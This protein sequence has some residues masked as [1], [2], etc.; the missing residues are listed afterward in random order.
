[1]EDVRG[2]E[3]GSYIWGR[4]VHNIR[5]E[6]LW[7]DVTM[8][9]GSKWK[10]LFYELETVHGLDVGNDAH[11]WLLH[12]IFLPNLNRDAEVWAATWNQHIVARRGERHMAPAQMYLHGLAEHGQCGLLPGPLADDAPE[13]PANGSADDAYAGYG[14]DWADLE[15][16]R[17]REH[18]DMHN[19]ND[20]DPS[21]PFLSNQPN[22]LSHV[23]VPDTRCPFTHEQLQLLD[24]QLSLLPCSQQNTVQGY[25]E[26]WLAA[27]H[28][29]RVICDMPL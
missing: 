27:L 19:P 18:H 17:I 9:F 15:H 26:L 11:V 28:Y 5:I 14:I 20:G 22:H 16:S 6:R 12:H 13:P 2:L 25:T 10:L 8:G 4:S 3:R 29:S 1:M 23:E 7:V 24:I 21:N